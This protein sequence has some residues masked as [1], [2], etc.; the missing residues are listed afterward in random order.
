ME[1]TQKL[2]ELAK[3]I[4][5]NILDMTTRAK[6]GHPSSSLSA[7]ELMTVLFFDGF[8]RYDPAHP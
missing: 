7:V 4:R 5:F 2:S 8:L 6:S 3:H 1:H